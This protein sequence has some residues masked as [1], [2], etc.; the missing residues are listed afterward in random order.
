[1][2]FRNITENLLV[3]T[4]VDSMLYWTKRAFLRIPFG[5]PLVRASDDQCYGLDY[6]RTKNPGKPPW[7]TPPEWSSIGCRSAMDRL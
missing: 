2:F 3:D 6:T 7:N 1:L 4:A 5:Q